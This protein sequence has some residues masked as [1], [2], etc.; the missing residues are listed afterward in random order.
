[1]TTDLALVAD[2]GG[3]NARLAVSSPAGLE[4]VLQYRCADFTGPSAVIRQFCADADVTPRRAI[5]GIAGEFA[6]PSHIV[7]TNG[8]WKQTP[9]SL[10]DCGIPSITTLGDFAAICY[11]VLRLSRDDVADVLGTGRL[12]LPAEFLAAATP[13]AKDEVL[14]SPPAQRFVAIGPGTGLGASAGYVT[15]SGQVL[16]TGGQGSHAPFAADTQEEFDLRQLLQKT[17]NGPVTYETICCGSGLIKTF[18]ALATLRSFAVTVD[19]A[20]DITRHCASADPEIRAVAQA[21][22]TVFSKAL[23]ACAAG[24]TLVHDAR[25][26]FLAGGIIPKLGEHFDREAFRTALLSNDLGINNFMPDIAVALI[27]HPQPGLLGAHALA[28]L[29]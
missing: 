19:D 12:F 8:P 22:L 11:S 6:D 23:G 14:A 18:N 29:G 15:T 7:F 4:D 24:V 16:V 1:M 21:T 20:A 10:T 27:T 13:A 5:I 2:F 3:T 28:R 9:L 26:I 25:S 17:E